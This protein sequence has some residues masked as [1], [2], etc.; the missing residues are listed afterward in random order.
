MITSLRHYLHHSPVIGKRVMVDP[1]S[2][3]IGQVNIGDDCSIWPHVVIRGDVNLII[4]GS[5]TNIQDGSVLHVTH[6]SQH[7]PEGFPL[8][9]GNNVTIGHKV[10][11]HGCTLGNTIL[12]GMG[13]IIMDNVVIDDKVIVGAGSLVPQGKKLEGGFLYLGNP[14]RKIRPL[15]TEELT[16]L[17][18]SAQHY[19][20]WKQDYLDQDSQ[21]QPVI[22]SDC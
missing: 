11:L 21:Y 17:S 10:I 13:A 15:T 2:L 8:T 3:V 20:T 4:I 1:S 9:I 18:D 22:S 5:R 19:V 6:R 14:A 7:T 12:I 16:M